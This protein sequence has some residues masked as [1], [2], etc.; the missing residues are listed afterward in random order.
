VTT[1]L[2]LPD[3]SLIPSPVLVCALAGLVL[4]GMIQVA[5]MPM[6]GDVAW[7]LYLADRVLEGAR[8]YV[9]LVDT[10]PPLIIAVNMAIVGLARG[11]RVSPLVAFPAVVFGLAGL[12]LGLSWRLGRGLPMALRQVSLLAWAYLLLVQ[13]GMSFGQREHLMMILI[14]PY[15]VGAVA[16]A[17]GER[18]PRWLS[19]TSGLLAGV[20][21][22]LKPF[23]VPAALAVELFLAARRGPR[24]WL[25]S[26]TL[27]MMAVFAA[28]AVLIVVWTPQYFDVARRFAP[29]YPYHEPFGP[30]LWASSWRLG[31]VVSALGLSWRLT[32]AWADGWAAVFSL[33][34]VWLTVGVYL[35]GKGWLYHWFPPL[36]I[37]LAMLAGVV[38][39]II[40]RWP[41]NSRRAWST[42]MLAFL[43][44]GLS[45]VSVSESL[46]Y[47]FR[48]ERAGRLVREEAG[49]GETV[50][51]L[52]CWV[53]RSFPMINEAGAIWGMRHPMLWQ[54]A[55]FYSDT[56]WKPGAYHSLGAMSAAERRFVGE[57]ADDFS[58]H[59]PTLLLVDDDPPLPSMARFDYL[60][61]LKA[62]PRFA[63]L[64]DEYDPV[65]RSRFFRIYR[66][67]DPVTLSR[68]SWAR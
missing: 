19:I 15:A 3:D 13:I 38:A 47:R 32:K 1:S 62:D 27:A 65:G 2:D 33:L 31:V 51:V 6:T 23:F 60:T 28:Y 42:G 56:P 64:L 55:A 18:L 5:A 29:L 10:N 50:L 12:S 24:V 66:R 40:S 52:S 46:S 61:Y 43:V 39:R 22:G 68:H 34:A 7:Y 20:G 8:P 30:L 45:I 16:E 37:A 57:V 48:D 4:A 53:H 25:R 21:F 58:A 67:R 14:L 41:L 44:P 54:I 17:R 11:I 35:T 26:Q 59:R 36:A 9:D 63:D 49:R